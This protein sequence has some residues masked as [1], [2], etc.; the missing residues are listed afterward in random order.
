MVEKIISS[1]D[2][3]DKIDLDLDHNN[4]PE[5]IEEIEDLES[6]ESVEINSSTVSIKNDPAVKPNDSIPNL[7]EPLEE[8]TGDGTPEIDSDKLEIETMVEKEPIHVEESNEPEPNLDNIPISKD[9]EATSE[10]YDPKFDISKIK[11]TKYQTRK[12]ERT[13]KEKIDLAEKIRLQGQ[14]EP[15]HIVKEPNGEFQLVAG[16]GRVESMISIGL[17]TVKAIVHLNCSENEITKVSFGTNEG[18]TELSDWDKIC[19]VG[20]FIKNNPLFSIDDPD[21]PNSVTKVFGYSKDII[22]KY[23]KLYKYFITQPDYLNV[24]R[25]K[26]FPAFVYTTL[27]DFRADIL[28]V[29]KV[30]EYLLKNDEYS[31]SKF[32]LKLADIA[33]SIKIQEKAIE[34]KEIQSEEMDASK[35]LAHELLNKMSEEER[36]IKSD[37]FKRVQEILL[38]LETQKELMKNLLEFPEIKK[39]VDAKQFKDLNKIIKDLSQIH[40]KLA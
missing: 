24:F 7:D 16:F 25:I 37:V 29:N 26:R 21:D 13:D 17:R 23:I 8:L 19:S 35:K 5:P 28:K 10:I 12:T 22:Y 39:H 30:V 36:K 3:F 11:T 27:Y 38:T 31:T 1:V 9:D 2:E 33:A 32:K 34:T 4:T 14:L 18:R 20:S 40:L 6:L 15:V